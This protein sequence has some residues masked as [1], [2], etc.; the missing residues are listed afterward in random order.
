M[1]WPLRD[2]PHFGFAFAHLLKGDPT[3]VAGREIK[4]QRTEE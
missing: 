1:G 2:L 4:E 3:L